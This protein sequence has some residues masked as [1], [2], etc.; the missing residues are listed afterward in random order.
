MNPLRVWSAIAGLAFAQAGLIVGGYILLFLLQLPAMGWFFEGLVLVAAI[1]AVKLLPI[2]TGGAYP[3][4]I[5]HAVAMTILGHIAS[6]LLAL[7]ATA[8]FADEHW[9]GTMGAFFAFGA[10]AVFLS[11]FA[12]LALYHRRQMRRTMRF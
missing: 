5:W 6:I 1:A 12:L 11:C 9:L 4:S 3:T 2:A 10:A 8:A 7:A